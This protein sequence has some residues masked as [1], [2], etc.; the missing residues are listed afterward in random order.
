M[1][2]MVYGPPNCSGNV[3]KSIRQEIRDACVKGTSVIMVDFNLPIDWES[4]INHS[5]IEEEFLEC[6]RDGFLEQYVEEPTREQVTLDWV[7]CNEKGLVGN[8]VVR[9]PLTRYR[10]VGCCIRLNLMGS[11]VR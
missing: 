6:I 8:L 5:T 2:G 1:V 10:R 11:R 3:G 9:E 7:L 4:Q